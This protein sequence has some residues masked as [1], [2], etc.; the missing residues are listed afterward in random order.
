MNYLK[1]ANA[2]ISRYGDMGPF[3]PENPRRWPDEFTIPFAVYGRWKCYATTFAG[4]KMMDLAKLAIK[5]IFIQV[6]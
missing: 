1:R 2:G 6:M 4:D 3:G 5:R